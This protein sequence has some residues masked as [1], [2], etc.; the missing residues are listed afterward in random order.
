[1]QTKGEVHTSLNLQGYDF[2]GDFY[3][4]PMTGCKVVLGAGWLRS[5]GDILWNFDT[6]KMRFSVGGQEY[7]L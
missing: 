6:M 2:D 5:L 1:M 3:I 4:L 7:L